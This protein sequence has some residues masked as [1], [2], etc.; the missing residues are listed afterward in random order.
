[1]PINEKILKKY[2]NNNIFIETGTWVGN[3]INVALDCGFG[4]IYSIEINERHYK[5]AVKNYENNSNVHLIHGDSADE[6]GL[7][8]KSINEPVTFWLDAHTPDCPLMTELE[9]IKNHPV[10]AHTILIDDHRIFGKLCMVSIVEDEVIVALKA[11][12]P[13]YKISYEATRYGDKDIIVAKI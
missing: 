8:L 11:I 13:C 12:S 7:L 9:D 10:K 1:M 4:Q 5:R 3:G 2:A 6:L